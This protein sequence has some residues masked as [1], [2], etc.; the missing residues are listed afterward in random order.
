MNDKDVEKTGEQAH[1][2]APW[3][4][5]L[6]MLG[7]LTLIVVGG[8]AA[9]WT[10]LAPAAG[11]SWLPFTPDEPA[12]GYYQAA[13]LVAIGLVILGTALLGRRSRTA[14]AD[15]PEKPQRT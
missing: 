11:L 12:T 13:K 3:W 4:A 10:F 8:I 15:E 2:Q 5:G 14:V 7:A 1:P 9:A 6:G